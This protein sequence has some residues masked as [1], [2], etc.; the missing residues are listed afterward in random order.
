MNLKTIYIQLQLEFSRLINDIPNDIIC[1]I[2]FYADSII[3]YPKCHH[4]SNFGQQLELASKL[5]S[6][7]QDT[8][9]S[10]RK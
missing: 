9:N 4:E 8:V 7:I 2:A 10:G 3:N 6:G 1:K 5:E